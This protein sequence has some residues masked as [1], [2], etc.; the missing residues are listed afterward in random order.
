M[1][2]SYIESS[3]I[4]ADRV[5]LKWSVADSSIR[6]LPFR[7]VADSGQMIQPGISAIERGS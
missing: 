5:P 7:F 3:I 1:T 6:D 2:A 4:E